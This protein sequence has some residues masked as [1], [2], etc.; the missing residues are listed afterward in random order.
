MARP[1]HP[2]ATNLTLTAPLWLAAAL[3]VLLVALVVLGWF[4]G[5]STRQQLAQLEAQV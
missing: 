5:F 4:R 3:P 1:A 2:L